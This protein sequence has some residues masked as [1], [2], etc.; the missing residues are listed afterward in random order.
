LNQ[1]D[2]LAS[3]ESEVEG[4]LSLLTAVNKCWQPSDFVPNLSKESWREDLAEFRKAAQELPDELIVVL[5]GTMVTEE[6]LPSYQT[7]FNRLG[8]IRDET[9]NSPN[10][11]AKWSR[12]WT[13]EENR[14]GD[15]LNRYLYLTGRVDMRAVEVTVQHLIRNGFNPEHGNDA[16][17]GLVYTSFQERATRISHGKVSQLTRAAGELALGKIC[18]VIAA[19]EARHEDAYKS[20]MGRVFELDPSGA[21]LAMETMLTRTI[22]MPAQLMSDPEGDQV[23][24]CFSAVAQ[25]L[26]VY[27]FTDYIAIMEHLIETWDVSHIK[28]LSGAAAEGQER[29]C[30]LPA[31]YRR[32]IDWMEKKVSTQTRLPFPWVVAR[33]RKVAD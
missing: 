22:T 10:P 3:I 32:R 24:A 20:F 15:L 29:I 28:G 2:V 27:T 6:A 16:Y 8:S 4:K 11:W 7:S 30:R 12:A 1:C 17:N 25:R 5:V 33:E 19:D 31:Y 9:G 21:M 14:H 26:G 18:N 23:F 13:A